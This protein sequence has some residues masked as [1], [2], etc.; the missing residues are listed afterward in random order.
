MKLNSVTAVLPWVALTQAIP[1]ANSKPN[2]VL[3][4]TDDQDRRLG[5]TDFQS[6]LQQE[7][8]AKGVEFSNHFGT[9]AQCCPGRTSLLRGQ[10][11]HNTN[12]THVHAPGGNYDKLV[13][14]GQDRDYLPVWLQAA[15]YTTEC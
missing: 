15:G 2:I 5:S 3:F 9:T 14:S 10:F 11:A 6:V 4:L 1:S 13:I 12:V 8:V 7:M